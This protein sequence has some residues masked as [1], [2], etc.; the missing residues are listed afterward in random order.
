MNT[1]KV[2]L[3]AGKSGYGVSFDEIPNVF[4]FGESIEDAKTDAKAA[5][6]GF[7]ELSQRT[8]KPLP[9]ILQ[10]D[11]QLKFELDT[12]AL[13]K[14][15]EGIVTKTALAKASG[16]NPA[17]LTHY[18]SGLKKPRKEQREKIING[19]HKLA[20]ELLSVS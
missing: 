7:I 15:V 16:I 18:S 14:H 9:K 10:E 17:Q 2:I 13:L 3:E 19:L 20:L 4:G 12:E 6:D 11:Y 8:G 1:I 5:L